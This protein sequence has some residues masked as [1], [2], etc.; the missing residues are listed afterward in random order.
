MYVYLEKYLK[1]IE[2]VSSSYLESHS[3]DL[4]H[5]FNRPRLVLPVRNVA[6]KAKITL[7]MHNDM[8]NPEKINPEEANAA[9]E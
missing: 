8:F 7:S 6:P 2:K 3:F 1:F 4:I 9:L 5:I